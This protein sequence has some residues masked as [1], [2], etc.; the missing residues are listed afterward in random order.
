MVF[1]LCFAGTLRQ[2]SRNGRGPRSHVTGLG[3]VGRFGADRSVPCSGFSSATEVLDREVLFLESERSR[4]ADLGRAALSW[5][6][7]VL[8]SSC[9]VSA[10]DRG[11][12]GD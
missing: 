7:C 6:K 8:I 2:A 10:G 3:A 4:R 9:F 12:G 1:L 5:M 11:A